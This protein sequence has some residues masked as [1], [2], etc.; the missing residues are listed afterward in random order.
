MKR[1]FVFFAC[2]VTLFITTCYGGFSQAFTENETE[3]KLIISGYIQSQ[4]QSFFV[5]DTIGATTKHFAYFSSGN[6]VNDNTANRFMLRRG[7]LA[8]SYKNGF[9]SSKMS[10]DFT[11]R[12]F[13]IK[14]MYISATDPFIESIHLTAG[15]FNRP[16]GQ[17]I[18]Y[19]SQFRETP[20]RSRI[21]QTLFPGE[22][23]LGAKL[24]FSLPEDSPFN[25]FRLDAAIVNGNGSAVETDNYKDFIGSI[26]VYTPASVK[27]IKASAGFSYYDGKIKH[28]YE[29]V[30]T[31]PSN[32]NTKYYIYYFGDLVD[33]AGLSYSGF[34]IDSAQ[35]LASG[36]TG[37]G[38]DRKY[39]S[40]NG[41]IEFSSPFGKTQIK[42]E[43]I[44]GSQPSPVN[45]N[46][47]ERDY[48]V[49]N[50]FNTFS[51]KGPSMGMSWPLYD[52]PQPYNPTM[53][54][55]REK[56]HSTVIRNFSGGY[57]YVI[58]NILETNHQIVIKYDWYNPNTDISGKD[59]DLHYYNDTIKAGN[60]L[61]SPADISFST[62]GI[63]WNWLINDNLKFT[64]YYENVTNE[65]TSI[66]YYQGD[67]RL[68]RRPSPGFLKDLQDDVLTIRLQYTF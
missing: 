42:G 49:Y 36:R 41:N 52:Q 54:G 1:R 22:R 24:S 67:I 9:A 53:A 68:G 60:T 56:Y 47:I 5:P 8:F 37:I 38:V 26:N 39:Y 28:I 21:I 15:L 19:S 13:N 32:V 31:I 61:I 48:I 29:P 58:Q 14:D 45:N 66:P 59:I 43:Y 65:I 23:D 7:R 51:P 34:Y 62:I 46:S 16:F 11:E 4:Y 2:L 3:G 18:A 35:T 64:L 27:G 50:E 30:D 57:I 63:G 33:T 44:W 25:F 10:L 40:V 20:E 12:G 55:L 17:E 6:F